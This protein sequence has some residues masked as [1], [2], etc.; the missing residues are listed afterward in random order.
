MNYS[1]KTPFFL[2]KIYY[3]MKENISFY[4]NKQ[5]SHCACADE[6]MNYFMKT[7]F[8]LEKIYYKIKENI[9]F[10]QNFVPYYR[11]INPLT[12]RMRS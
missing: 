8:C 4:K 5:S 6:I 12:L 2:E 10:Y 7:P 9:M 1:M 11:N 3:K